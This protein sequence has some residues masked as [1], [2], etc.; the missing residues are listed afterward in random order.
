[1]RAGNLADI[2]GL[3]KR[4]RCRGSNLPHCRGIS[5]LLSGILLGTMLISAGCGYKVRSSVGKLPEGIGSLGIP[6]FRNLTTQYKVEQIIS[7]AVLSEFSERTRARVSS[8]SSGVDAV[9]LGDIRSVS[10]VPVTFGTQTSGSQTFGSAF[11]VTVQIG[12][13]LV[14]TRD[15]V[16]IWQNEDFLYRE[17]YVLNPNVRD[18][19]SEENP[20]LERLS[21]SFAA[22]LAA[23]IL[24]RANP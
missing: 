20:A 19:F 3:A 22:A 15:S 2:Y 16:V 14:R 1:M 12:A 21:K 9:L 13:R 23:S 24:D 17:R 5:R 10:A 8:S 18:F 11:M 7:R 4:M 6:T